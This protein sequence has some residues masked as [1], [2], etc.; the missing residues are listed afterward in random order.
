MIPWDKL[1]ENTVSNSSRKEAT[2][3]YRQESLLVRYT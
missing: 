2:K 1:E 3:L